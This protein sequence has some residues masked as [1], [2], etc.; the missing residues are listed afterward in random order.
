MNADEV[1]RERILKKNEAG[2][3][4]LKALYETEET[5]IRNA[6]VFKGNGYE[7]KL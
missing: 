4:T 3:A 7:M 5:R 2:K 6:V 1:I